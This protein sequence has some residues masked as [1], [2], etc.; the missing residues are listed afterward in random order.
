MPEP[1]A[2][3]PDPR[4][5]PRHDTR[6]ETDVRRRKGIWTAACSCGWASEAMSAFTAWSATRRHLTDT[7]AIAIRPPAPKQPNVRLLDE[8]ARPPAH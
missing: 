1:S 8:P 5:G 7:G 2:D 4:T 3:R 6:H